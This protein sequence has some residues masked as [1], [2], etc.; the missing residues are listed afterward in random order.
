[1][2]I[3]REKIVVWKAPDG[4][5]YVVKAGNNRIIGASEEGHKSKKYQAQKAKNAYP[6]L[7]IFIILPGGTKLY[8]IDVAVKGLK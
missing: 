6:K 4:W 8:P 7:P 5:R 1:M 3:P 2:R